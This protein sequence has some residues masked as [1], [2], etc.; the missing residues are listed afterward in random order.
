MDPIASETHR[1]VLALVARGQA[2]QDTLAARLSP[3]ERAARGEL[4][5]WS[6]K[7][8]VAH[9]NFWRQ[10]A[11]WRLQAALDG[12]TPPDTDDEQTQNDRIFQEQRETPWETLVAET[13]RLRA[14]TAA[15]IQQL[16]VDD[17]SQTD[18]YPWQ[19]GGS[20]DR[21]ILVNWYDH[22]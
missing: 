22:P 3:E 18:R 4:Q 6:A 2:D 7:D 19:R 11:A 10:D 20:L 16:S 5:A 17:L 12:G 8:H 1:R 9:N 14:E 21:L 13:E 15:L